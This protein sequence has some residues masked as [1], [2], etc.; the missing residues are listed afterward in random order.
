MKQLGAEGALFGENWEEELKSDDL[1]QEIQ[2]ASLPMDI[3]GIHEQKWKEF[4]ADHYDKLMFRLGYYCNN[5]ERIKSNTVS[6][7]ERLVKKMQE[8]DGKPKPTKCPYLFLEKEEI[9]RHEHWG[10]LM[11]EIHRKLT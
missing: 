9:M 7:W 1:S 10:S 3:L 2:K 11:K 4:T 6:N 5:R 8:T